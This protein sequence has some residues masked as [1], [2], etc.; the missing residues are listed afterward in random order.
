MKWVDQIK[1]GATVKEVATRENVS[2][3]FITHNIDLAYLS[4]TVLNGMMEGRQR[5]DLS[6]FQLTKTRWPVKW[7]AQPAYFLS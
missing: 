6:T 1:A 2:S 3:D 7:D 4:P 5:Q